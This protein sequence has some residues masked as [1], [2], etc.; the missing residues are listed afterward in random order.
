MTQLVG[1]DGQPL[2]EKAVA[3]AEGLALLPSGD[4]LVSFERQHR[5]WRYPANGGLPSPA[6]APDSASGFPSNAGLEALAA[7]PGSAPGTYLAGSEGGA[8]WICT[9]VGA[10]RETQL[11]TRVPEDYGLT[12]HCGVA[13]RRDGGAAGSLVRSSSE[14]CASSSGSLAALP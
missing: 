6:P 14:G 11:G 12:A 2:V 5:I 10:C 13:G 1:T 8:V 3:D 9:F 4:R 7:L